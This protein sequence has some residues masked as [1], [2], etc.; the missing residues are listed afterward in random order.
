MRASTSKICELSLAGLAQTHV[1]QQIGRRERQVLD[2]EVELVVGV[3]DARDRDVAGLVDE[4]REDDRAQ[5]LPEVLLVLQVAIAV[6]EQV[7]GELLPVVAE[8]LVERIV[9]E[10]QRQRSQTVVRRTARVKS[11]IELNSSSRWGR[12]LS[13][14]KLWPSSRS[15]RPSRSHSSFMT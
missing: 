14:K 15:A 9:A 4:G 10:L 3:L 2:D 6:E 7:L 11:L 13:L 1:R 12:Y 5:V 8:L